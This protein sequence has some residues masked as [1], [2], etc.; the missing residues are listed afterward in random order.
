MGNHLGSI[1]RCCVSCSINAVYN[2][3]EMKSSLGV[4]STPCQSLNWWASL[5]L[6]HP[7]QQQQHHKSPPQKNTFSNKLF[8]HSS[9]T[10]TFSHRH[11]NK[12]PHFIAFNISEKCVLTKEIPDKSSRMTDA[13]RTWPRTCDPWTHGRPWSAWSPPDVERVLRAQVST[14]AH[15][16]RGKLEKNTW[17]NKIDI[18]H[19]QCSKNLNI[20]HI[21]HFCN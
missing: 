16:Q 8:K 21:W 15:R 7:A 3:W 2:G 4:D 6:K 12:L 17:K 11:E 10:C 9:K 5:A 20:F 14:R 19:W 18:G 1:K 13:W